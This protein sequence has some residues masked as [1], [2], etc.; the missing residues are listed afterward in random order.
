MLVRGPALRRGLEALKKELTSSFSFLVM[1]Q[2]GE[3]H[4]V[5]DPIWCAER[6]FG[7]TQKAKSIYEGSAVLVHFLGAAEAIPVP[8][9][10]CVNIHVAARHARR[11]AQILDSLGISPP[12]KRPPIKIFQR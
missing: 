7:F 11:I 6:G 2:M 9:E 1:K 5:A 12:P 8:H 3:W 4:E 10:C